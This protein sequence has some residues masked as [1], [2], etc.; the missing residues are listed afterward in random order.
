[1]SKV[2]NFVSEGARSESSQKKK[3]QYRDTWAAIA[4]TLQ[5]RGM[6]DRYKITFDRGKY[7]IQR[8]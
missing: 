4:A 3:L 2:L 7:A 6:S 1:M 5:R 8:K